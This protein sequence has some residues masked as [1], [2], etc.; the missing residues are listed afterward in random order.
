MKSFSCIIPAFN[1]QEILPHT[2]PTV[3]EAVNNVPGFK[4]RVLL[5]DNN[6]SDN[7]A[8]IAKG[9]GVDVVFEPVNQISKARNCGGKFCTEDDFLIFIDA[10][11]FLST[12][13]LNDSLKLLDSGK[14]AGGGCLVKMTNNSARSATIIWTLISRITN[15][16]AGAYIFCRNDAF[17]ETGGFN[18]NIYAAEDV[19]FSAQLKKWGRKNGRKKFRILSQHSIITS[20]RKF[21]WYSG[22]QIL[23]MFLIIGIMPWRLKNK[24][25]LDFWY[26][27]PGKNNDT[28]DS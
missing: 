12:E 24:E 20:D 4:G 9:F 28:N 7:T 18:E 21:K 11:T 5:V 2:L 13:L 19:Y 26:K 10:D 25:K 8:E 6:S 15:L 27:R 1:E 22:F 17:K 14:F 3:I 16:A 23:K